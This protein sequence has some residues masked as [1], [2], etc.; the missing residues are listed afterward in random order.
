[1]ALKNKNMS[2][3]EQIKIKEIINQYLSSYR[4]NISQQANTYTFNIFVFSN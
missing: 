2:D 4:H 1:M 3:K